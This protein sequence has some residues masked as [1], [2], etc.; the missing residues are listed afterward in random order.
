MKNSEKNVIKRISV[1][2][3]IYA[4]LGVMSLTASAQDIRWQNGYYRGDGTYVQGHYKTKPNAYKYDNLGY[5]P[6][7]KKKYR[8][9]KPKKKS[10]DVYKSKSYDK[11]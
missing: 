10:W 6:K 9:Y 7:R 11:R 4:V 8:S 3:A 5:E 1:Y 2:M